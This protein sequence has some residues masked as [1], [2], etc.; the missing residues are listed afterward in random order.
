MI[1]EFIPMVRHTN[2]GIILAALIIGSY[3]V[4]L[5]K[6]F[7]YQ[8]EYPDYYANILPM[9][10]KCDYEINTRGFLKYWSNCFSYQFI[11]NDKV[12]PIISSIACVY[13]VYALANA[14]TRDRLIGLI[15]MGVMT[16][17]PLLIRFDSSATYDQLW[18]ALFLFSV[19]LF[20]KKPVM[21]IMT[22]PISIAAK[23][24]AVCFAPGMI[25]NIIL[26]KR[27]KNKKIP[28]A[29]CGIGIILGGSVILMFGVGSELGIYPERLLDGLLSIFENIWPVFP[30]LI[31]GIVIDRFFTPKTTDPS[32]R[33]IVV[34]MGIILL[35]TPL[36][37]LFTEEQLQ[38]G[39][40]FVPFGAFLSI[41]IGV[42]TI[43][44]GNFIVESRLK[45]Q[46][47]KT[48]SSP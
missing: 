11:G 1:R 27:I 22:F 40:R 4:S 19:L 25:A 9:K 8:E 12:I 23:I 17:N 28:L 15:A 42:I 32:K 44:F 45:K 37:Y 26:D 18:A 36:L 46:S 31:G 41:Y 21:G 35:S 47:L 13:L 24:L 7:S 5:V 6:E 14:I 43:Q 29:V 38:F 10:L 20:Y 30:L 34:W 33:I 2:L 48:I 3:A 39:Y 16:Y